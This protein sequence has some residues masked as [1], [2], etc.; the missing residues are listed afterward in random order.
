MTDN[1]AAG[2]RDNLAAA[3]FVA[4]IVVF[5]A[6]MAAADQIAVR[7]FTGAWGG[8]ADDPLWVGPVS[9]AIGI[10]TPCLAT[11]LLHIRAAGH[12][13]PRRPRPQPSRPRRPAP[14][15]AKGCTHAAAV[16]VESAVTGQVLAALCPACDA[17]LP[18]ETITS[19]AAFAGL[20]ADTAAIHGILASLDTSRRGDR[21][22][23]TS[24]SWP[25]AMF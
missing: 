21:A 19:V 13:E 8:Q 6:V 1:Q 7:I 11:A 23:E 5:L 4:F 14:S 2:A 10:A 16:P 12:R 24:P 3:V 15:R 17:Q 20:R 18:A 9:A 25:A 22:N